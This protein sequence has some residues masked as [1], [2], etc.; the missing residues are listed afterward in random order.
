MMSADDLMRK[1][2]AK[3]ASTEGTERIDDLL[4]EKNEFVDGAP[5]ASNRLYDLKQ[6]IKNY[7]VPSDSPSVADESAPTGAYGSYI[8]NRVLGSE[9]DDS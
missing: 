7:L 2:A 5:V 4:D 3:K 8:A 9:E 1:F 6:A